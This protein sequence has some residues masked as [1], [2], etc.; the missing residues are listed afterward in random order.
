M[1]YQFICVKWGDKYSA[2]YVNRLYNMISCQVSGEFV[3]YCL[4]DND[5]GLNSSVEPLEIQDNS[6]SGWWYKLSLF[7][8]E[9]YGLQGDFLYLD[10]DVVIVDELDGFFAYKPGCFLA[11]RDLLTGA[12]NSSVFRLTIGSQQQIWDSFQSNSDYIMQHYKGDQDWITE[13][14]VDANIWP[15]EWVVSFKKQCDARI[16][17]TYGRLGVVLRKLGWM[18]VEG[19]AV[20]PE[21]ARVVQ[22]HGKPD[23]EDV[24]DGSYDIYKAAPWIKKYWF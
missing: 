14:V 15:E 8:K 7:Q 24:M 18:K 10:L 6:L 4:T 5:A 19:E 17:R 12:L 3:L 23:P 22:F 20:L 21:G 16:S 9:L 2:D 13:K 1:I 11:S